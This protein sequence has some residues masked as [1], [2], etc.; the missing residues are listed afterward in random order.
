MDTRKI[1]GEYRLSHWAEIMRERKESGLSIKEFCKSAGFHE[2]IYYYWQ[3][4]LRT[5]ACEQMASR[6][7]PAFT[8]IKML[9]APAHPAETEAG[10]L[11]IEAA[12]L[13]ITSDSSYPPD[14]LA[15]LLRELT[16]S[17]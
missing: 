16:Q 5:A 4:K 15:V 10:H 1:A 8:E 17:C 9:E 3:R 2:N 7:A 14:K 12:G 11:R 6:P 13:Q